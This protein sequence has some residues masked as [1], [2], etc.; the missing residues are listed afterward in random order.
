MKQ[1]RLK[2]LFIVLMLIPIPF[3]CDDICRD[4][5]YVTPYF[6]MQDLVFRYVDTYS[7]NPKTD[8][9]MFHRVSQDYENTVYPC[10]SMAL[11]IQAPDTALLYHSQTIFR[12]GFSFTQEVMAKCERKQPG[13]AGTQEKIDKIWI[14]SNYPFDE[15]HAVDYDLSDIVDIFAYTTDGKH[16]W[17]LLSDYNLNS[18]YE[19]PKRFH[20]L[21]KRK[22]TLSQTQQFVIKYNFLNESGQP[23]KS[24][25]IVTPVFQVR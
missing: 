1:F 13:Y 18:P 5:L 15:T 3:S 9:L 2:I 25:T 23:S 22:P 8:K 10:D 16:S 6:S 24:F 14:S 4:G 11:Y 19:A 12:N 7:I 20:L 17:M 21:L